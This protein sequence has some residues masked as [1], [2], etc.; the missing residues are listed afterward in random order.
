MNVKSY[1]RQILTPSGIIRIL[2]EQKLTLK[3]RYGQN[4][5][6]NPDIAAA[7]VD[8]AGLRRSDTVIEIGPGLGALT[9]PAARRVK[10]LVACEV[11]RGFARLL[12]RKAG[13]L[14]H[15][16]VRVVTADFLKADLE[17]LAGFSPPAK[18]ISNFPYNIGIRAIIRIVENL[19]S[20]ETITGTVQ[21][22]LAQRLL[23][24]PGTKNYA[25]VSVY[26]QYMADIKT[27]R[28][29]ISPSNFFPV[30]D[31]TSSVIQVSPIRAR[32]PI[33][34]GLFRRVVKA[35]FASRR[36]SLL[37]NLYHLAGTEAR[38]TIAGTVLSTFGNERVRAEALTVDDFIALCRGL[39]GTGILSAGLD[40]SHQGGMG[41]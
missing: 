20:V 3:K 11:D 24:R 17:E 34:P 8:S 21:E 6:I 2:K 5:L 26:I 4:F 32:H 33:P 38:E 7:V 25:A 13:L 41:E 29:R 10:S 1:E 16:N 14:G 31:V 39:S 36:K 40:A 27:L 18:V 37:N 9:F 15:S 23:A 12:E 28:S 30:P 19:A 35:S 22:E